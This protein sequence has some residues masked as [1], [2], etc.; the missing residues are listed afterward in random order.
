MIIA[1]GFM[2]LFAPIVQI[3]GFVTRK[4]RKQKFPELKKLVEK[5][6]DKEPGICDNTATVNKRAKSSINCG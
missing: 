3:K 1:F 5:P 6:L 4:A 2:W